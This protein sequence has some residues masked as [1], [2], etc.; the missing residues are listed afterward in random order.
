MNRNATPFIYFDL[1]NVLLFFDH[2]LACQNL[3]ILCDRPAE[4]IW[5]IIFDSELQA[6]YEDG[7]ISTKEFHRRF[8]DQLDVDIEVEKVCFAASAIFTLNEE[9]IPVVHNLKSA[10]H[11]LGILSNTCDAHWQYAMEGR[12]PILNEAFGLYALSFE[13]KCSKPQTV[14]Y[15]KAAELAGRPPQE[16]FFVDDRADNVRGALDSGFDAVQFTSVSQFKS[17]LESRRLL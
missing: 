14:I 9:I 3:A 15:E 1:G 4:Q 12:Y 16:I 10:G 5:N 17:E 6:A 7:Q 11:R 13:L 2:Q 8:C